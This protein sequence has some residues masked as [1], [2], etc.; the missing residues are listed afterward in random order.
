[1][2][3]KSKI[4]NTCLR[5]FLLLTIALVIG[6]SIYCWNAK[7]LL[8]DSMPMPAG[9]GIAVVLS[10]SMEPT[11]SVDDV[12]LVKKTNDY[13]VDDI[14]VYQKGFELVVHRIIEI[15]K[16]IIITQGD[17]NNVADHEI[18]KDSIK[19]EVIGTIPSI[20]SLIDFIKSPLGI[21]LIVTISVCLYRY[22]SK[23]EH[24]KEL[25]E[26]D[27]LMDKLNDLKTEMKDVKDLD[28]E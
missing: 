8:G 23:K 18:T 5:L 1:M 13:E 15:K 26:L 4:I 17:A 27:R 7:R 20:G 3:K 6:I 2:S 19:G 25:R 12:I 14:V 28:K 16:D 24:E 11:L 9:Y 22:S 10:G 21:I